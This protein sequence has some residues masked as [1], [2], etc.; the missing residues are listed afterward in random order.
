MIFNFLSFWL[1][2]WYLIFWTPNPAIHGFKLEAERVAAHSLRPKLLLRCLSKRISKLVRH[3]A[4]GCLERQVGDYK[5][6][7]LGGWYMES[8]AKTRHAASQFF[9]RCLKNQA[10]SVPNRQSANFATYVYDRVESTLHQGCSYF[11]LKRSKLLNGIWKFATSWMA[12]RTRHNTQTSFGPGGPPKLKWPGLAMPKSELILYRSSH[13]SA[14]NHLVFLFFFSFLPSGSAV[15]SLP[16]FLP[17]LSFT[18][19]SFLSFTFASPSL[20]F[21]SYFFAFLRVGLNL[22]DGYSK[23]QA[24]AWSSSP[25]PRPQ[26]TWRDL[27]ECSIDFVYGSMIYEMFIWFQQETRLTGQLYMSSQVDL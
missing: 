22:I 5:F 26:S 9:H 11:L 23:S 20:S 6:W 16:F 8:S 21:F 12:E 7:G 10:A 4:S 2:H 25:K 1:A 18:F 14:T 17:V 27:E 13:R 19:L 3:L 24:R 15:S